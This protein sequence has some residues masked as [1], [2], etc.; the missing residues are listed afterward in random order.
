VTGNSGPVVQVRDVTPDD[1]A[2]LR[3]LR[4]AALS[5]APR[6]FASNYDREAAFT[7]EQWRTR[8]A[9][10]AVTFFA[11]AGRGDP[12]GIAGPV[13]ED[14][15]AYL[16]SMWVR[17]A[18]RGLG[19]GEVLVEAAVGWTRA[20]GYPA[21]FLWVTESNTAARGLYQRCGFTP[22]G[23]RDWLPSDPTLPELQLRRPL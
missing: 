3:D 11:V 6:A 15:D 21:V 14:G 2:L 17:P 8:I 1:W 18:A 19:V 23:K 7:E 10:W 9:R 22:T 4:L 16:G 13:V 5:G 12:A 20:R